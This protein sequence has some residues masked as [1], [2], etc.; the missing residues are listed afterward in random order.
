MKHKGYVPSEKNRGAAP[1]AKQGGQRSVTTAFGS[2]FLGNDDIV[3][4]MLPNKSLF[5]KMVKDLVVGDSIVYRAD[6][7]PG[8]TVHDIDK[9][10]A[11]SPNYYR[12][13]ESTDILF[14]L[15]GLRRIPL[16]QYAFMDA[17]ANNSLSWPLNTVPAGF[18]D[19]FS[20]GSYSCISTINTD[21]AADFIRKILLEKEV[22]D[23]V[24]AYTI[25]F[26]WLTGNTVAPKNTFQVASALTQIA[27]MMEQFLGLE[28][29][30]A[31]KIYI[32]IR[33]AVTRMINNDLRGKGT[34]TPRAQTH[35]SGGNT[36]KI[37][38]REEAEAAINYFAHRITNM[39]RAS[40]IIGVSY[41]PRQEGNPSGAHLE[42]N[43]PAVKEPSVSLYRGIVTE[44]I[45]DADISVKTLPEAARELNVLDGIRSKLL[46]GIMSR[47]EEIHRDSFD[48]ANNAYQI[49]GALNHFLGNP[50]IDVSTSG[51][52]MGKLGK[53][54]F[55][56]ADIDSNDMLSKHV[57]RYGEKILTG[58]LDIENGLPKYTFKRIFEASAKL[59]S[60]M[61]PEIIMAAS[62]KLKIIDQMA[63]LKCKF[64]DFH[65]EIAQIKNLTS[66]PPV[67]KKAYE[68]YSAPTF[69]D[70]EVAAVIARYVPELSGKM[71]KL[72]AIYFSP[73]KV[74][75]AFFK[76]GSRLHDLHK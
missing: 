3:Y 70:K 13:S 37:N 72:T 32:A 30:S 39:Y 55:T 24:T 40:P 34:A 75:S 18:K 23:P 5:R 25:K 64:T 41:L 61:P 27:P 58:S 65:T 46:L 53:G 56:T 48:Y 4:V 20:S 69:S 43:G 28:F 42:S 16:L 66:S 68:Q 50:M 8:V 74:P 73:D 49:I 51:H 26:R 52:L 29:R 36:G 63:A 17:M 12:Y 33:S 76:P 1:S 21:N 10:L 44:K 45:S 14:V 11:T 71:W 67:M 6:Q 59:A 60:V 47:D 9:A 15:H 22:S 2:S 7:I 54:Q 62:I 31:Y 19:L 35:G 57:K 38:V